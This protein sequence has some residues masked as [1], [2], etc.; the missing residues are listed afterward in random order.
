MHTRT[1]CALTFLLLAAT[2]AP[3]EVLPTLPLREL[4]IRAD[5]VVIA[6]PLDA[7][8]PGRFRV[9][10]LLKGASP[11]PG[12]EFEVA[13]IDACVRPR[14]QPDWHRVDA[15]LLF[16]RETAGGRLELVESGVRLYTRERAVWWPVQ[17]QNPG[18]YRM[19]AE[20]GVSWDAT[21]LRVRA[22]AVEAARVRSACATADVTRRD[23]SLFEW[24]DQHRDEFVGDRDLAWMQV[25]RSVRNLG[26]EG[27]SDVRDLDAL[28]WGELQLTPFT[29]ILQGGEPS[30]CLRAVHLFAE[31]NQGTMLPDAAAALGTREGRA[32]LLATA[33]D[34][35][36]LDGNR[37]RALR[38]L[39][40]PKVAEKNRPDEGERNEL[41]AGLLTLF[42]DPDPTCR[43]LAARAILCLAGSGNASSERVMDVLARAYKQEP[44]GP[45]RNFMAESLW[46]FA[47][48]QRWVALTGR[49]NASLALMRDVGVRDEKLFFW[50]TLATDP[51]LAVKE[52]PELVVEWL[53]AKGAA[54][55]T[56]RVPLPF[57]VPPGPDGWR[58]GPRH[59]ELTHVDLKP[60]TIRMTVTGVAGPDK[61]PWTTEPR[62]LRVEVP[63]SSRPQ[64]DGSVLGGFLRSISRAPVMP[65]L[66]TPR[67]DK[68]KRRVILDG[69]SF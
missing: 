26:E 60:G 22:D 59:V 29:R 42:K 20:R 46:R 34:G 9:R 65:V 21:V 24:V 5:V 32:L 7:T 51:P 27:A 4:T 56:K 44:P 40:D 33:R 8:T 38:L 68:A 62:T 16:L 67:P 66:E 3:A 61:L 63:G 18:A 2:R 35:R 55:E 41:L 6:A 64:G 48:P 69:D 28:G 47:G 45:G 36:Q 39:G 14:D 58:G 49:P 57:V 31:L 50:V 23:R 37:A 25:T 52:P 53:D 13:G 12:A 1:A 54:K 15:A 43:G 17:L 19:L 30:D 10:E 11:R